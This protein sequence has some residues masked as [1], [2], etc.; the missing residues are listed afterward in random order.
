M[1]EKGFSEKLA[2]LREIADTMSSSE[3]PIE[4]M[5]RLAEEGLK[6]YKECKTYLEKYQHRLKIIIEEAEGVVERDADIEDFV[7]E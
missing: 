4:E 7:K 1:E 5:M 2:R 6:L 3:L